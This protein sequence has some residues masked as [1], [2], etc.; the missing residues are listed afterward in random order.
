MLLSH[1]KP[2]KKKKKIATKYFEKITDKNKRKLHCEVFN[3]QSL[4]KKRR[5]KVLKR[6]KLIS[7][8]P[9]YW[10]KAYIPVYIVCLEDFEVKLEW[11]NIDPEKPTTPTERTDKYHRNQILNKQK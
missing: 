7:T 1:L 11:T 4:N 6:R 3:W 9:Q 8:R 10:V 5:S 2:F